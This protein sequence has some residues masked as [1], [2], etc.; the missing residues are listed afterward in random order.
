MADIDGISA[1]TGTRSSHELTPG[2]NVSASN[3]FGPYPLP[4]AVAHRLK[5]ETWRRAMQPMTRDKIRL[6]M[7]FRLNSGRIGA[8][9]VDSDV[10]MADVP[11]TP[12]PEHVELA[13][14]AEVAAVSRHALAHAK[15]NAVQQQGN[16]NQQ[17]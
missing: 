8:L 16:N 15:K 2:I 7:R 14:Q 17:Q 10:V 4:T 13:K 5:G 11:S 6:W 12:S 3:T 9:T 1:A